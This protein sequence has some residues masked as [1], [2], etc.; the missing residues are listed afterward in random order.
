MYTVIRQIPTGL[1][2]MSDFHEI[3]TVLGVIPRIPCV[4][5]GGDLTTPFLWES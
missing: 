2:T 4:K 5:Y 1:T 3:F